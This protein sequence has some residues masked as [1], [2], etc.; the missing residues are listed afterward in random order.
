MSYMLQVQDM[1][2]FNFFV[3]FQQDILKNICNVKNWWIE[4]KN[5]SILSTTLP[6]MSQ[7]CVC[8]WGCRGARALI[9][10]LLAGLMESDETLMWGFER[11]FDA[12]VSIE[13]RHLL[14]VFN[15]NT[16]GLLHLYTVGSEK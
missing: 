5:D 13:R 2:Y 10:P 4:N 14:H 7:L 9:T 1:G 11:F 8:V 3:L 15:Q 16:S 6:G 12:V